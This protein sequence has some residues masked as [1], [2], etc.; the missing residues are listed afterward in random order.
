MKTISSFMNQDILSIESEI[1]SANQKLK[2]KIEELQSKCTHDNVIELDYSPGSILFKA[3]GP[4]RKCLN[5]YYEESG[6]D[7]GYQKLKN[8][9]IVKKF[10]T[11]DFHSYY[12]IKPHEQI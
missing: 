12:F 8:S 9:N 6:W 7:C 3:T 10:E 11:K 1:I 4:K 5:C 2:R